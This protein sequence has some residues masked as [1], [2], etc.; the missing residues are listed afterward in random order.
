[1]RYQ[2]KILAATAT[3]VLVAGA[4]AQTASHNT[5]AS[6]AVPPKT[7]TPQQKFVLDTVR[8][9]VSLPEPDPQDRL[10]VLSS[11][12][13]VISPI[14]R[15]MAKSFWRE[16]ARIESELI[17]L[18]KTP[19]VS[20]LASGQADC[21]SARNFV[22][23]VP[24]TSVV[25]AEQ[26]LIGVV[27]I[28][29]KQ[30]LQIVARRLSAALEKKIV[31]PRALMATAQAMGAKSPWSQTH[32]EKLFS[33]LPDSQDSTAES[34]NFAA[35][36]AQMASDV[37]KD[38]AAKTG[39][40]L[41]EWLAKTNDIPL[42]TLSANTVSGA[43]KHA[44]GEKGFQAALEANVIAASTVHDAQ[45]SGAKGGVER[46]PLESASVLAAMKNRGSDQSDRLREM[47]AS[48]RAREAAA[49]GFAAGNSREKQQSTTYF[50]MAFAAVDEVWESRTPE[51]NVAAV[52]EEVSEAA[53]QIDPMNA[54]TRAQQLR[55]PSA[56][57]IAMLAVARVVASK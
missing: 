30:T 57:A 1:M 55:D 6:K 33:S 4:V 42:R 29:P 39:L 26:A 53:A 41:L 51:Q 18:G 28:C 48:Q 10:R 25:A 2:N 19:A 35:F 24:E 34:Q 8:L 32:F 56:Q 36:Y 38:V 20:F 12:A 52:V 37:D 31:A 7:L 40:E 44:L 5:L 15:K 43:M 21:A 9:A 23:N 54:M 27:T 49:H 16:G 50:D 3:L 46:P 11:A 47:P 22:E 17:Q 13:N 14:D 45:N